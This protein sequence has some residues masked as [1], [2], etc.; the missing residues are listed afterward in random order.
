MEAGVDAYI[1]KQGFQQS[2]LLATIKQ[3]LG[4]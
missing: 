3:L 2:A 1:A 4:R